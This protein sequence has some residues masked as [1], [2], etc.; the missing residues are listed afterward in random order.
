MSISPNVRK[1]LPK[2][3]L[4]WFEWTRRHPF[5][6]MNR[7]ANARRYQIWW[8]AIGHR[9]PWLESAARAIYPNYF[10]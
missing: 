8:L 3:N 4:I 10:E 7:L 5:F 1:K 2:A 6:G 9:A